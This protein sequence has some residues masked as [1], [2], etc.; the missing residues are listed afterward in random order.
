[1]RKIE[2]MEI[3]QWST[4]FGSRREKN[5][6]EQERAGTGSS[7]SPSECVLQS[8]DGPVTISGVNANPAG[9][10]LVLN[11]Y[12]QHSTQTGRR[13]FAEIDSIRQIHNGHFY[14]VPA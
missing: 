4:G 10:A 6:E 1:M 12:F 11:L 5:P 9:I 2:A 7:F 3:A 8:L 13:K 14:R